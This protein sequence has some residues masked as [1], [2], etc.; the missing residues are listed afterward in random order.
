VA[1]YTSSFSAVACTAAQDFFEINS[2]SN[3]TLAV[4]SIR[5]SQSTDVGDAA[6][7]GWQVTLISGHATSGSGGSTHTPAP[8]QTGGGASSYTAEINNT[9]IASTGTPI[10][11]YSWNWIIQAPFIEQFTPSEMVYLAPG[12]RLCLRLHTTP[13]DSVT[14]SGTMV[15]EEFGT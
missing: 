2:V 1:L 8:L 13:A 12:G 7:E 4:H 5:L 3:K 6:A 11:H 9:T 14:V 10:T 15:V